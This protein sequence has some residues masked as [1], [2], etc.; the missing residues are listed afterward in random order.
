MADSIERLGEIK[1]DDY[2]EWIGLEQSGD[3]L[4]R[5]LM[6]AAVVDMHWVGKRT[7]QR[8]QDRGQVFG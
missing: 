8:I 3:S 2:N 5:R 6:M 1:R 4:Y 7:G